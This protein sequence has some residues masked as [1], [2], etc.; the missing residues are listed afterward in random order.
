V[1]FIKIYYAR[2]KTANV[3]VAQKLMLREML[4]KMTMGHAANK[5]PRAAPFHARSLPMFQNRNR[6]HFVRR[7][8]AT[9]MIKLHVATNEKRAKLQT[10]I[11]T[12]LVLLTR[13]LTSTTKKM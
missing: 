8:S 4:R 3:L 13:T 7:K 11:T 12:W 1:T 6:T 5:K 9:A 2:G 10:T